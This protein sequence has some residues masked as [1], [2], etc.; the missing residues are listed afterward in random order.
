MVGPAWLSGAAGFTVGVASGDACF[1]GPDVPFAPCVVGGVLVTVG[2]ASSRVPVP[3]DDIGVG[4]LVDTGLTG[5]PRPPG[6]AAR[7]VW[8]EPV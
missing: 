8:L 5:S 3:C 2:S 4:G 6:T 1:T 7:L